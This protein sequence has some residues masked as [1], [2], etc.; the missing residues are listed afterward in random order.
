MV[1]ETSLLGSACYIGLCFTFLINQWTPM[2]E[3]DNLWQC[4]SQVTM[5]IPTELQLETGAGEGRP[6]A[7]LRV[8][9]FFCCARGWMSCGMVPE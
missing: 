3:E 5:Q 8:A 7:Y 9:K 4:T 2:A 1:E 6:K